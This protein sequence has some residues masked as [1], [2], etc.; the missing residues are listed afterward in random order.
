VNFTALID[1]PSCDT[2]LE[3]Q[4]H[5]DSIDIEQMDGPPVADQECPECGDVFP[6]EYPGWTTFGE[7]G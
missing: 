4:W 3:G 7:A 6:A 2:T 5:D 1:C